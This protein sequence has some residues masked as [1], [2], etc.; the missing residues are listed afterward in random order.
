MLGA[1]KGHTC[2]GPNE[3]GLTAAY[4]LFYIAPLQDY[5]PA[6]VGCTGAI[7]A[8]QQAGMRVIPYINGQ[9]CGQR[10]V[11][12]HPNGGQTDSVRPPARTMHPTWA[13]TGPQYV[14]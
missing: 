12:F 2:G 14:G 8:M 1:H 5:F 4:G 7:K 9:L 11:Q 13:L 10:A 3:I 6:R